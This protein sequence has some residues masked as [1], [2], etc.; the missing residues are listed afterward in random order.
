M[1]IRIDNSVHA[2]IESFY[3]ISMQL[4]PTLDEA[5]VQAKKELQMRR[6]GKQ[7]FGK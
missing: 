5:V 1:I 6:D 2:E 3:A 7:N 4:H